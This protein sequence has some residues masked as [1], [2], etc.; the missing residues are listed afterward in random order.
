MKT[1]MLVG[2]GV[3][4]L[5]ILS[6][7][8][9]AAITGLVDVKLNVESGCKVNN[10]TANPTGSM[11]NFG[12]LNFGNTSTTW[13]NVLTAQ[14]VA[15]GGGG[16]DLTVTCDSNVN[17]FNVSIDGGLRGNRTLAYSTNN[18]AYNVYQDAARTSV[19]TINTPVTISLGSGNTASVPIY[20]SIQVQSTAVNPGLYTD[21]L[22]VTVS[23]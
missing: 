5:A 10:S 18:I 16:G 11:N 7:N 22:S 9:Q 4:S 8:A 6:S 23:F 13:S 2:L 14:V 20:G 12:T 1:N 3:L 15:S 17:S 21:T 19:Y